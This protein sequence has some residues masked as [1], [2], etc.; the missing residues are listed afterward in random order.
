MSK[1]LVYQTIQLNCDKEYSAEP[2]DF[3]GIRT[4]KLTNKPTDIE[5]W[6]SAE[7]TGANLFPLINRGDGWVNIEEPLQNVYIYTKGTNIGGEQL[8]LNVTGQKDI[9]NYGNNSNERIDRV[10]LIEGFSPAAQMQ[11][12]NA[13]FNLWNPPKNVAQLT[14]Q[15]EI[16]T[17]EQTF[18]F[19]VLPVKNIASLQLSNNKFYKINLIG[20][21][22]VGNKINDNDITST[23]T[24]TAIAHLSL[25]NNTNNA[26]LTPQTNYDIDN[27][28]SIDK[29][30]W[31]SKKNDIFDI[32]GVKYIQERSTW[33]TAL[34]YTILQDKGL[35]FLKSLIIPGEI[36]NKYEYFG[37]I[38]F[39]SINNQNSKAYVH[40]SLLI[41]LYEMQDPTQ[42]AQ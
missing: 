27:V 6:I 20:H 19:I 33:N 15:G 1:N 13:I 22:D 37:L 35:N 28:F 16:E 29:K 12:Q 30:P 2:L 36:I 4:I 42:W 24:T 11:L 14:I 34:I 38:F 23:S 7:N 25:F 40:S 3:T 18:D 10:G 26:T 32:F 17:S 21:I 9:F 31:A 5:V 8:I 41:T 39:G